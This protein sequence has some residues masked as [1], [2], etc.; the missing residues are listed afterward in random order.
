MSRK[1]IGVVIVGGGITGIAVARL[2][3]QGGFDD[4]L[5]LE[6]EREAGGLCRS[7]TVAGHVLDLGGGHFLCSKH[8]EVYEFL[9]SH[10]AEDE[11]Q[12]F[13]RVSTIRLGEHVVDYPIEYNLWQLPLRERTEYL[14]ACVRAGALTGS[15]A[16]ENFCE[17]VRW[18]LGDRIADDYMIAYN[19]KIWGVEPDALDIDWLEKLPHY[20]L[21]RV[22]GSAL[23]QRAD[24]SLM[25]S[26]ASFY[27]PRRGGFQTL[28]DA[29]HR[30]V[31]ERVRLATP[32]AR[33]ERDGA[34]WIVNEQYSTPVIVNTIPWRV[35]HTKV[36]GAPELDHEL[37][38]LQTS[39]LVVSL[40]EAP[41]TH[42]WHWCYDP[43]PGALHH[44]EF[45]IRNFAPHSA[46][47][48]LF[49][50][51]G[52][53]RF[54]P[55]PDALYTHHNQHAYPIPVRGHADASARVQRTYAELGVIG[56][57]RWGQHRYFNSDVC[58]REAM[59][60]VRGFRDGGCEGAAAAM[61]AS[62]ARSLT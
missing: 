32:L 35:F 53:L 61:A 30:H 11:L 12:A 28:F 62:A 27:Y 17:W 33:L 2:L 3:Q 8:P 51:T 22:V 36:T 21:E 54:V 41:Y 43:N 60:F 10:L 55:S 24:R 49:R 1:A 31:R 16:P 48:G 47:H 20:D 46:P 57:G 13:E 29:V 14:I 37:D 23:E 59:R 25:P 38:R 34:D 18:K 26:H 5:V 9:F 19:R 40:H 56:V 6:A 39:S 58:I 52:G 45:F 15:R 50:E 42:G 4:F 7:K 44:R